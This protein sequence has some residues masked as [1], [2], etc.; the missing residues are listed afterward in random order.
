MYE[1]KLADIG[2]GMQEGDIV[3]WFVQEGDNVASDEPIVSIQT[4]KVT[5]ELPSPIAG[6]IER[7]LFR[8]GATVPVGSTLVL[9]RDEGNATPALPQPDG[10]A[11]TAQNV[12]PVNVPAHN[13]AVSIAQRALAT[14]HVRHLAHEMQIDI[15]HVTGTGKIGRVTEDDVRQFAQRLQETASQ[16]KP[17]QAEMASKLRSSFAGTEMGKSFPIQGSEERIPLKGVRKKIAEHMVKSVNLIPHVTHV[18][19]LEMESLKQLRDRVRAFADAADVKLTF[20]PFFVKAVVI[21]L[22]DFPMLN[23][24]LDDEASEI[25]VKHFY[26]IGIATDTEEGL[27]VPVVKDVDKKTV[28]QLASEIGQLSQAARTGKLSLDQ[29]TGGTFTISNVG[30]IGGLYATP[31]INHPE[32]AIL[33]LHKMEPRTVVR[34][35]ESVIRTMMNISLSFDHRII[36]GAMAVR[37]TNRIRALLET[38][39]RLFLELA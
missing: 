36:D 22:R 30:S 6:T 39:E 29:I 3:E 26:H 19:E 4:D 7:I 1:F 24:S 18:D 16:T 17:A 37:F 27:I 32:A 8:E 25:V 34:N 5:A 9:I 11:I 33:G 35:G 21:A 20:L 23:A 31:I 28:L 10:G 13:K 12:A 38:P 14:P 15:E 2:E